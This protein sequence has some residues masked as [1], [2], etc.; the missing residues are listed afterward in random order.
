M[1]KRYSN[2]YILKKLLPEFTKRNSEVQI[3]W[4]KKMPGI[5]VK[6]TNMDNEEI[7]FFILALLMDVYSYANKDSKVYQLAMRE[8]LEELVKRINIDLG[9]INN[10]ENR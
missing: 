7:S 3:R 6:G 2:N 5:E 10:E 9:E 1:D 8:G 4:N